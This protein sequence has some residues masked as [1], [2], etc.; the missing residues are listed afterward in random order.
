MDDLLILWDKYKLK[1]LK[2]E[3]FKFVLWEKLILN[4]KKTSFN[5]VK[6]WVKFIWYK[7]FKNKIFV[8]K[9]IKK[10]FLKFT[11][12]LI[13]LEK[14]KLNLTKN[15]IPRIESMYYSRTWC[16]KIT[17]FWENFIKKRKNI[18]FLRGANDNNGSNS[19]IF[20][21][22]LNRNSSNQNNNVGGRCSSNL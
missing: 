17:D 9:R 3:I 14:K 4:P 15:D 12:E 1:E 8:W 22:N 5:L 21:M 7:I 10:S 20:T 16:F 19:G 13:Y 2:Q 11:D 18:D 6:D